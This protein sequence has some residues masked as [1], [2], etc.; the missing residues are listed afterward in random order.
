MV[1]GEFEEVGG[2]VVIYVARGGMG[3]RLFEGD[4]MERLKNDGKNKQKQRN[5][6][7]R[8]EKEG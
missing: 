6:Q 7:V 1:F 5:S 8:H 3:M 4:W 2:G